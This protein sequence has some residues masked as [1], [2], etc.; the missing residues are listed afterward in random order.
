MREAFPRPRGRYAP[1]PSGLLHV[2]NA[3]TALV[4]WLSARSAGGSFLMRVEDLDGPRTVPGAADAALRD[5]AWLGLDWDEGPDVGGPFA[6]YVQ[7]RRQAV[8]EAAL[9]TLARA[10]RLF[11]C[12]RSRKDLQELASAPHGGTG[13]PAYPRSLRPKQL[14]ADWFEHFRTGGEK[15]I[16]FA[17]HDRPVRFVDRLLGEQVERVDETAGDFVLLRRDGVWAYQLAVV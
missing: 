17:V 13:S 16:R 12:G 6:P 9:E 11:P 15:A 14:A 10:G 7:S 1:T 8:Y 4:A 2:G 3:R 5:L